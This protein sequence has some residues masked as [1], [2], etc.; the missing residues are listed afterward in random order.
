MKHSAE[1]TRHKISIILFTIKWFHLRINSVIHQLK[2]FKVY[3]FV[4]VFFN[5]CFFYLHAVLP[6]KFNSSPSQ[7][8][9]EKSNL[10]DRLL[11]DCVHV[12]I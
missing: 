6:D 10:I 1:K 4:N 5:N 11:L 12:S 3:F 9:D 8:N 2:K 7:K